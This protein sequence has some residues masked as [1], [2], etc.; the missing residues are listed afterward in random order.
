MKHQ[1]LTT[2]PEIS[3]RMSR[4]KLKSGKSEVLLQKALWHQGIRYRKNYKKLPGSPDIAIT[5]FKIAIFVDGGFWH[6]KDWD[7]KKEQIKN[8]RRKC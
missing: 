6:G 8:N 2:T 5:K 3:K 7:I 1:K 4:V